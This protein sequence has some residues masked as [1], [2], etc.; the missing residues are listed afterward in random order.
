MYE[1]APQNVMVSVPVC[2]NVRHKML[3]VYTHFGQFRTLCCA[4]AHSHCHYCTSVT[5][6]I[7]KGFN[8]RQSGL[9]HG[10]GHLGDEDLVAKEAMLRIKLT[11]K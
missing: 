7:I 4:Y 11:Q 1:R 10:E 9:P 5:T 3:K 6:S 8:L 2:M